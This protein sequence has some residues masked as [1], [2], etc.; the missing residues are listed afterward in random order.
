MIRRPPRS[1]LFPYTTLFRSPVRAEQG[2]SHPG[3]R[4]RLDVGAGRARTVV[5]EH[6]F[7]DGKLL[8]P[9]LVQPHAASDDVSPVLTVA[10]AQVCLRGD[11]VERL[12][13]DQRHLALVRPD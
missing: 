1:T 2:A 5:L 12:A 11:F 4:N 7:A 10:D 13:L 9:Q 6:R 8:A 3:L